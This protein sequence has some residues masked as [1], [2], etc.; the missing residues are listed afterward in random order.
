VLRTQRVCHPA[1][2]VPRA[3]T[4]RPPPLFDVL[5][6]VGSGKS[7]LMDL[8]FDAAQQHLQLD[9]AR[10]CASVCACACVCVCVCVCARV[11]V[12]GR[13]RAALAGLPC[14]V[15]VLLWRD[16]SSSRVRPN[17]RLINP[18]AA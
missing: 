13:A 12:S 10:R 15:P 8:F 2:V 16:A 6:S 7:L 9:H 3:Q 1:T 18:S 4:R 17:C 14:F 11:C 5:C